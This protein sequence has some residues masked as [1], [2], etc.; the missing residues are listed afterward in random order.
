MVTL[1]E[2]HSNPKGSQVYRKKSARS[3]D[4]K[5]IEQDESWNS[6]GFNAKVS[7]IYGRREDKRLVNIELNNRIT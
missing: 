4:P 7:D 3:S 2:M 1:Q 5:G 6:G